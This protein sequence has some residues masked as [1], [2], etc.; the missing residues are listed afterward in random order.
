MTILFLTTGTLNK[1]IKIIADNHGHNIFRIFDV[2]P[3]FPFTTSETKRVISNK[4]GTYELPHEL[5]N[6]LRL[7]ILKN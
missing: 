4:H 1:D 3:N 2:L 6:D 5:P 7:R